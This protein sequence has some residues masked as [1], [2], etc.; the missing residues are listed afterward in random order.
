VPTGGRVGF[1]AVERDEEQAAALRSVTELLAANGVRPP[2]ADL[3]ALAGVLP[4]LR[5]RMERIHA[6][7]C[8]DA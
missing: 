2:T 5:S 8:G 7:D 3:E 4:G 6:V 1:G